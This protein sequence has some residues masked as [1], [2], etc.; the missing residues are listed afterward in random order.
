MTEPT[1]DDIIRDASQRSEIAIRKYGC[2]P[3]T[4]IG[5]RA[6]GQIG[7]MFDEKT[8]A[9]AGFENWYDNAYL[10]FACRNYITMFSCVQIVQFSEVLIAELSETEALELNLD[11]LDLDMLKSKRLESSIHFIAEDID[12]NRSAANRSIIRPAGSVAYLDN[13]LNFIDQAD[14]KVVGCFVGFFSQKN[15][16]KAAMKRLRQA[17]IAERRAARGTL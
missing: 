17:M 15:M 6:D 16:G 12:G 4:F 10:A 14:T 11:I 8:M 2:V 1:L 7:F 9:E 13:D 3:I 5:Y